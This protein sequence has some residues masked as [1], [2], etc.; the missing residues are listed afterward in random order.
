MTVG[1]Q[2][3]RVSWVSESGG[4][5]E[6]FC[7]MLLSLRCPVYLFASMGHL[8]SGLKPGCSFGC[9]DTECV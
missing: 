3:I 6:M 9:N 5:S 7:T 1:F 2:N 8:K 4:V